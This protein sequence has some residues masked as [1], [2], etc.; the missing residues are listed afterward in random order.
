MR[1]KEKSVNLHTFSEMIGLSSKLLCITSINQLF[2]I[3]FFQSN[4]KNHLFGENYKYLKWQRRVTPEMWVLS[5]LQPHHEARDL[6][7]EGDFRVT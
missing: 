2:Q 5:K 4:P 1:Y 3:H 6:N 7:T